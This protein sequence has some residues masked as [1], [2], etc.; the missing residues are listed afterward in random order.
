MN[1][2]IKKLQSPPN[3]FPD[4]L[5]VINDHSLID[6]ANTKAGVSGGAEFLGNRTKIW[7][8]LLRPSKNSAPP[9]RPPHLVVKNDSSLNSWLVSRVPAV[10]NEKI[11][12][13]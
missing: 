7:Y 9:N 3:Q 1:T 6:F 2:T 13:P 5:P 12:V 10:I 4:P 11:N 8:L